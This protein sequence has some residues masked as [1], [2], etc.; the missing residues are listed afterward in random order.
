MSNLDPHLF[1]DTPL[2]SGDLARLME[3]AQA[4]FRW[5]AQADRLT[6][7]SD[8]DGVSVTVNGSGAI[9]ALELTDAAC[10]DGGERLSQRIIAAVRAAQDDLSA[11]IRRSAALT[12]GEDSDQARTVGAG[13]EHRFGRSASVI[14]TDFGDSV[15]WGDGRNRR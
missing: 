8:L 14:E 10:A 1:E 7:E 5:R 13:S 15:Q 2:A 12:F 3:Q 4:A 11:A 6:G 9:A